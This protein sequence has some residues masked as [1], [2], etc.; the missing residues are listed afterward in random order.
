MFDFLK[1]KKVQVRRQRVIYNPQPDITVWE[2][3][4]VLKMVIAPTAHVHP[5]ALYEIL[6]A[7]VQRHFIVEGEPL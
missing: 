7:E 4:Q 2:L 1:K 6:P 5:Y 3:A